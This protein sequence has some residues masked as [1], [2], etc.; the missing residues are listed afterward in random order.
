MSLFMQ[1]LIAE[2]YGMRL[3][4]KQLADVL[5]IKPGTLANWLSAGSCPVRTYLDGGK[6]FA[7]CRDVAEHLDAC[8]ERASGLP[9]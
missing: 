9:A 7:D 8:R 5:G 4:M 1:A 6:R 3:D 2:R